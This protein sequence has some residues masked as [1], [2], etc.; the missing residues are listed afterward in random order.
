M[1]ETTEAILDIAGNLEEAVDVAGDEEDGE[2]ISGIEVERRSVIT[3]R[4]EM[5]EGFRHFATIEAVIAIDGNVMTS[6]EAADLHPLKLDPG[7]QIMD[8]A[9]LEMHHQTWN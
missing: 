4:Q 6:S 8:L 9:K 2:R 5:T 7:H 1:V 3:E